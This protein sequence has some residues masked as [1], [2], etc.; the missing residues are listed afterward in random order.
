[1]SAFHPKRT[2]TLQKTF[3]YCTPFVI[4][5][6][7]W[8]RPESQPAHLRTRRHGWTVERQLAFLAALVPTRSVTLA[9]RAVGMSRESAYRLRHRAG[10]FAALWDRALAPAFAGESHNP[11][12]TNGQLMRLLGNHYRRQTNGFWPK[13]P[14]RRAAS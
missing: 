12:W 1:M 14:P 2:L 10:L 6:G 5:A 8:A 11:P 7:R 13:S 3:S 4:Q 9:A